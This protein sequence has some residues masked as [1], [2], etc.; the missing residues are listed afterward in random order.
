MKRAFLAA[1]FMLLPAFAIFAQEPLEPVKIKRE[2]LEDRLDAA[3]AAVVGVVQSVK[4]VED[5]KLKHARP[6][7]EKM[8]AEVRVETVVKGVVGGGTI[9]V[10]FE[11][12]RLREMPPRTVL[13]PGERAMLFLKRQPGSGAYGFIDAYSGKMPA[14]DRSVGKAE[15]TAERAGW[16]VALSASLRLSK[17][18]FQRGEPIPFEVIIRNGSASPVIIEAA[19]VPPRDILVVDGG[20]KK[21]KPSRPYADARQRA[22]DDFSTLPPKHFMG[23]SGDLL[24]Y[25][26]ITEPGTYAVTAVITP[27]SGARIG[28]PAWTGSVTSNTAAFIV[29]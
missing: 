1:V 11:K 13:E 21:I 8:V 15:E 5:E 9:Y 27:S 16:K 4:P 28:L 6:V 7:L 25:F 24:E 14:D 2:T 12:S 18:E 23:F 29:R 19:V 3:E 17:S 10:E 22:R 26:P 20:G